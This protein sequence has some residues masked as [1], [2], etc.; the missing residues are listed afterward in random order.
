[1]LFA[2]RFAGCKSAKG[3]AR[4]KILAKD[5]DVGECWMLEDVAGMG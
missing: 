4:D 2:V 1:M 5:F 3:Q